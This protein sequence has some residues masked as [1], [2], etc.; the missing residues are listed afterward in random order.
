MF[1]TELN[2]KTCTVQNMKY[3][4]SNY[5][6]GKVLG[7]QLTC[8]FYLT[9]K[10]GKVLGVQLT[11]IFYLTTKKGNVL[12]VQLT[13]MKFRKNYFARASVLFAAGC[14]HY[15]C[16]QLRITVYTVLSELS[17]VSHCQLFSP[18][19]ETHFAFLQYSL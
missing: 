8:I 4:L 2:A 16:L 13:C 10:K 3:F 14:G 12:G 11:C 19:F 17:K 6:K 9:T 5:E 15:Y 18:L 1:H 7:V